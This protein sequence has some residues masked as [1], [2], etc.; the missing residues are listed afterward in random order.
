MSSRVMG[1]GVV[2]LV[3]GSSMG[4]YLVGGP[5]VGRA[6]GLGGPVVGRARGLVGGG[7]SMN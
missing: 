3:G 7:P 2:M 1:G 6:R 5:V 4:M